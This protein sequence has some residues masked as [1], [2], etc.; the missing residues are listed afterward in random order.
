MFGIAVDPT[1]NTGLYAV[2]A[3]GGCWRLR[4]DLYAIPTVSVSSGGFLPSFDVG[5]TYFGSP[6]WS[7]LTDNLPLLY[8]TALAVCE[9]HPATVY[10]VT[11]HRN[12][13]WPTQVWRSDDSGANWRQRSTPSFSLTHQIAIDP[14]DPERLYAATHSGLQR[15]A[16]GGASWETIYNGV[17]WDLALDPDNAS[18]LYA[19][20]E[21]VGVVRTSNARP[22]DF[23]IGSA[24]IISSYPF[25][26]FWSTILPWSRANAPAGPVIKLSVGAGEPRNRTIAAKLDQEV[27][28]NHRSGRGT[29]DSKGKWGGAGYRD[30][31]HVV[32]ADP[33]DPDVI[34]AGAENLFRTRNSGEDWSQVAGYGS[35]SHSDQQHVVFDRRQRGVA[36]LANDGG[37]WGSHDGGSTWFDLNAG[38][39]TSELFHT[40]VSGG[41]AM[42][43]MYH[44]GLV[45]STQLTTA[46]WATI[47]GGS[48]EFT[49]VYGDP[50]R[51]GRFYVFSSTLG[52]R[53][54]SRQAVPVI[55][56]S[57]GW[58]PSINI[59]GEERDVGDF[60]TNVGNFM[61]RSIEFDRRPGSNTIVVG[62]ANGQVM[63]ALDGD[64]LT[65]TWRAE[66][67]LNSSGSPVT[68]VT[69][70]PNRPARYW[71][72]CDS[73]AV[74]S[75]TDINGSGG[76]TAAGNASPGV[77]DLAVSAA[78]E[79]RLYALH[80]SGVETSPDGGRSWAWM[81]GSG[82]TALPTTGLKS[83]FSHPLEPTLVIVGA[84]GG[85]FATIDQGSRWTRYDRGL[86][87]AEIKQ[88][89]LAGGVLYATTVGRGLWRRITILRPYSYA[90]L[91]ARH[92]SDIVRHP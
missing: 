1:S 72:I 70:A 18:I 76:W 84:V 16:D 78:D 15:S 14:D 68:G 61:P 83:V 38:L 52:L 66:T 2:A 4:Y 50:V 34:L 62:T 44:Q 82:T 9:R 20:V 37:I 77:I 64:S 87:N 21:N 59:R 65:P 33:Y 86:P 19:G 79:N 46:N 22:L 47:E 67:G 17:T 51:P 27:F 74:F 54:L 69:F 80:D 58:P 8:M 6:H 90:D 24:G 3:S 81:N 63:R 35:A 49:D 73:G 25:R 23:T 12:R 55:D 91:E 45:A 30:W 53:R 7:P 36:Y 43:D 29:W 85:I 60:N 5:T 11:G 31:C 32:A 26:P 48:W 88:V 89:F 71:A 10:C 56:V 75:K 92:I 42:A 57:G 28:L 41:A 39:V 40:G 13:A